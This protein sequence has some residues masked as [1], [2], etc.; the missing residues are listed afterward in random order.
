MKKNRFIALLS[1]L[2]LVISTFSVPAMGAET[3]ARFS[4]VEGVALTNSVERL[5]NLDILIGYE[6]GTFKPEGNITRAEFAAVAVRALGLDLAAEAATGATKF[7]DVGTT[8][9]AR[10][11]IN[12]AVQQ[13]I[14]NGY[15]DGTFKPS[16][17][18]T[19]AEVLAM[20]VRL[21]GYE[22]TTVGAWPT[23]YL[24][25]SAQLGLT[26]GVN[27]SANEKATRAQVAF[28]TDNALDTPTW[29]LLSTGASGEKTFGE[30]PTLLEDSLKVVKVSKAIIDTVPYSDDT[31][32]ANEVRID[33]VTGTKGF[34]IDKDGNT[35]TI[36][37]GK[38]VLQ[39]TNVNANDLLGEEVDIWVKDNS[40]DG[41]LQSSET[42]IIAVQKTQ[43]V[44]TGF[45]KSVDD[46]NGR[47]ELQD[48]NRYRAIVGTTEL[49]LNGSSTPTAFTLAQLKA[50]YVPVSA[51]EG[52]R[53]AYVKIIMDGS[54]IAKIYAFQN[55]G[56][57]SNSAAI[58]TAV[59]L[60][61]DQI[62]VRQPQLKSTV[63]VDLEDKEVYVNRN[64]AWATVEDIKV[65]DVVNV[66]T[67]DTDTI[68]IFASDVKAQGT[69]DLIKSGGVNSNGTIVLKDVAEYRVAHR[70]ASS[71]NA[72][73]PVN[74]TNYLDLSDFAGE[75][76]VLSLNFLGQA[77]YVEGVAGDSSTNVIFAT[78]GTLS[79]A[80]T[81]LGEVRVFT[82]S[83]G[84]VVNYTSK[85]AAAW[86][87]VNTTINPSAKEVLNLAI[88]SDGKF[89]DATV[90]ATV[91][92]T[93][94]TLSN[95]D[96]DN[97]RVTIA[98]TSYRVT[99]SSKFVDARDVDV[100]DWSLYTW[101]DFKSTTI[102]PAGI[103]VTYKLT[104][105]NVVDY[106]VITAGTATISAGDE[107]YGIITGVATASG[108]TYYTVKSNGASNT[109][110][111]ATAA[112]STANNPAIEYTINS[113][114]EIVV[115]A[116]NSA[117]TGTVVKALDESA[118]QIT[119]VD[120]SIEALADDV[121]VFDGDSVKSLA[122]IVA[123]DDAPTGATA[124]EVLLD[125]DNL[126]QVI[127]IVRKNVA[128]VD[129]AS[130]VTPA[131]V[132]VANSTNQTIT[133]ALEDLDGNPLAG[134]ASRFSVSF[135]GAAVPATVTVGAVTQTIPGTYTFTV[136]NTDTEVVTYTITVDGIQL[137]TQPVV[138]T[139]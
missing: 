116:T 103:T 23:K 94:A 76:A 29:K 52:I 80:S 124:I 71:D 70:A 22:D 134:I 15:P 128:I 92:A 114:N 112:A 97:S 63:V 106:V 41:I 77:V 43:T 5:A 130:T 84:K 3:V 133:V 101:N 24:V 105:A 47:V 60:S 118:L 87:Q 11:F 65:G 7:P 129:A 83:E 79:G 88:D 16:D 136:N 19:H 108:D 93:G 26:Q 37:A 61:N 102:T 123:S 44:A 54:S 91:T 100:A 46:G 89:T 58:V 75:K 66:F 68:M 81:N 127:R 39:V 90:A 115:S 8:H 30:G 138:T 4:D 78:K 57:I 73:D 48:G 113:K 95:I 99:T 6:D 62:R 117:T 72:G 25:K 131:T 82:L 85:N 1:A 111:V 12:V 120:G 56:T 13:G 55:A 28:I 59:N 2:I 42:T 125:G 74:V 104:S 31:L 98:G 132:T 135:A 33:T 32:A 86:T 36:S 21:L 50:H 27:V 67:P 107:Q 20:V 119:F 49:Y 121:Q 51:T 139:N 64:G 9:W 110:K 40:R 35:R 96:S 38:Y 122:D 69:F 14:I 45:V 34:Y 53:D 137:N 126:V 17:N 109:Y 18:V 10:G